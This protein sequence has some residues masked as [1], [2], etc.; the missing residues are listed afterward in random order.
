VKTYPIWEKGCGVYY[1]DGKR[2]FLRIRLPEVYST[3]NTGGDGGDDDGS[4]GGGGQKA[5]L[6]LHHLLHYCS[7]NPNCEN[8][9]NCFDDSRN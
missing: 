5:L 2:I 3:L 1:F 7:L 6:C 8:S 9:E 4:S